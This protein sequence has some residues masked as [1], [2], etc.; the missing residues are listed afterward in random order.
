MLKPCPFDAGFLVGKL[1]ERGVSVWHDRED[2]KLCV[3]PSLV[4]DDEV[5]DLREH[6]PEVIEWLRR[7]LD[8]LGVDEAA[9]YFTRKISP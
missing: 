6:K 1:R 9:K 5:H 7:H 4:S 2:H 3:W 8:E